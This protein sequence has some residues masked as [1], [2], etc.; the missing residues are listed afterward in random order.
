[1]TIKQAPQVKERLDM[2]DNIIPACHWCHA[3]IESPDCHNLVYL[4]GVGEVYACDEYLKGGNCEAGEVA[5]TTNTSRAVSKLGC[6][7]AA[8]SAMKCHSSGA[9]GWRKE[10]V[11]YINE[12]IKL[13]KSEGGK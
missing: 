12:S 8:L 11:L 13:I 4:G 2:G 5:P 9:R 3:V 1:M 7:L 6:A 10:A